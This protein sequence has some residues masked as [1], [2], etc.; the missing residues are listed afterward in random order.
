[1]AGKNVFRAETGATGIYTLD[2]RLFFDGCDEIGASRTMP[3]G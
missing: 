3:R 2:A 1:M